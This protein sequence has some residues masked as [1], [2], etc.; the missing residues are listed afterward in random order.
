MYRLGRSVYPFDS[1]NNLIKV[2]YIPRRDSLNP[3]SE[4]GRAVTVPS[5]ERPA[6]QPPMRATRR[7]GCWKVK[8]STV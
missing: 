8:G 5:V 1:C 7:M 6:F 3:L 4:K 2:I